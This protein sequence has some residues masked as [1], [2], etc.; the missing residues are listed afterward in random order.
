MSA[1]LVVDIVCGC[2]YNS[3]KYSGT[4]LDQYADQR[5]FRQDDCLTD[6]LLFHEK[7]RKERER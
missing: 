5:R 6:N 2:L 4:R 7:A 1:G 3:M